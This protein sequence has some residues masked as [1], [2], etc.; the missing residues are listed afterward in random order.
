M[1]EALSLLL[2]FISGSVLGLLYFAG[3][4]LT[5]QKVATSAHPAVL[6]MSSLLSRTAL[7]LIGFYY[8]SGGNLYRL[9]LCLMSFVCSRF[10]ILRITR[11]RDGSLY[12]H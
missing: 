2:S 8:V 3:L 11:E 10:I 4:W 7:V 1:S 6:V 9:L 12:A 5:V